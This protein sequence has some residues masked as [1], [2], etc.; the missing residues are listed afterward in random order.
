MNK[1]LFAFFLMSLAACP[2]TRTGNP[3]APVTPLVIKGVQDAAVAR[4]SEPSFWDLWGLIPRAFADFVVQAVTDLNG[5]NSVA[6]TQGLISVT[7]IELK[8]TELES[9]DESA[10]IKFQGPYF[11][12]LFASSPTALDEVSLSADAYRRI[13]FKLH[14][15]EESDAGAPANLVQNSVYLSGTING[16]AF[17]YAT[18]EETEVEIIGDKAYTP[19]TGGQLLLVFDFGAIVSATNLSALASAGNKNVS[20]S[21][22]I[23]A[24][25][26]CPTIKE[27][28]E[29]LFTC[30]R[31]GLDQQGRFGDDSD[32]DGAIDD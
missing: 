4:T 18:E 28:A 2:G 22:R 1:I 30:F 24:S 11:A 9:D 5:T 25:N 27:G 32:K 29:D 15:G 13:K 21:N 8:T 3:D 14:K 10:E 23:A 7:D 31:E 26:P 17:T 19:V 12:D 16:N 20:D 6:F